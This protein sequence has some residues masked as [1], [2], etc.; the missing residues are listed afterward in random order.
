MEFVA[1]PTAERAGAG[2]RG[3]CKEQ[4]WFGF[5]R[6]SV[7][8]WTIPLDNHVGPAITA[9]VVRMPLRSP[10]NSGEF[11][12]TSAIPDNRV[13]ARL[14]AYAVHKPITSVD[15]N[16]TQK[17]RVMK[18][19]SKF[20]PQ[21]EAYAAQLI[22]LWCVGCHRARASACC[23]SIGNGTCS[24]KVSGA[25]EHGMLGEKYDPLEEAAGKKLQATSSTRRL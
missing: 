13:V 12:D 17:Q 21:R 1:E 18:G 2:T 16:S 24:G 20:T 15:L 10:S 5:R 3:I 22:M 9:D 7:R 8:G 11:V 4:A 14:Y 25:M 19:Y 6:V 23:G